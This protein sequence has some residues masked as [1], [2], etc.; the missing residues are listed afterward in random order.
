MDTNLEYIKEMELKFRNKIIEV[1]IMI[2]SL[3]NNCNTRIFVP[4]SMKQ[5][6]DKLSWIILLK[7]E[8]NS[9]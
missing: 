6:S 9:Y 7:K 2:V 4:I 5:N 8:I 3:K 1:H